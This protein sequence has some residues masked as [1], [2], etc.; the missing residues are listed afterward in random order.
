MMLGIRKFVGFLLARSKN[1]PERHFLSRLWESGWKERYYQ[2][3]FEISADDLKFRYRV[4][5]AYVEGLCWVMR[6]YYQARTPLHTFLHIK[7]SKNFF[8]FRR[9]V[10]VGCGIT[11]TITRRLRRTFSIWAI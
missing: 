10:P 9:V 8:V 6:Y 7:H 3:K 11:R 4:A 1:E 5:N 2:A